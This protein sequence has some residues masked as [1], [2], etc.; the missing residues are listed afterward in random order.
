MTYVI[1]MHHKI[2]NR[3]KGKEEGGEGKGKK[4]YEKVEQKCQKC[5]ET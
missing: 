3:R 2:K 5:Q 4:L 1:T